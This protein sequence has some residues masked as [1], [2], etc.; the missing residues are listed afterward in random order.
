MANTT[1]VKDSDHFEAS[2]NTIDEQENPSAKDLRDRET[3]KI[4]SARDQSQGVTTRTSSPS[5][6]GTD[7]IEETKSVRYC[8]P[9]EP[10]EPLDWD[11]LEERYLS[12]MNECELEERKI[13]QEFH[14][15]VKVDN[16]LR[17][18]LG[19]QSLFI[20]VFE[21]WASVTCVHENDRAYKRYEGPGYGR[22]MD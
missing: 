17:Y 20:K 9:R 10:M 11:S 8:D 6:L 18:K 5:N 12:A 13:N 19:I 16:F 22:N 1:D 14:D 7:I 15:W 4:E 2:S 21:T 3:P